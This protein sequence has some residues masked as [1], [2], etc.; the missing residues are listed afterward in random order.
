MKV[1][2]IIFFTIIASIYSSYAHEINVEGQVRQIDESFEPRRDVNKRLCSVIKIISDLEGFKYDSNNGIVGNVIDEPGRDYVYVS[3]DERA[4]YVYLAGFPRLTVILRDTG[5]R[6]EENQIWELRLAA[7]HTVFMDIL[8]VTL[9]IKPEDASVFIDNKAM[10]RGPTFQ[11][12]MG[13]HDIS[14]KKEGYLTKTDTLFVSSEQV[15]FQYHLVIQPDMVLVEG[16]VYDMGG[17]RW[18]EKPVHKVNLSSFE[19][20]KT[21]VTQVQWVAVMGSNPSY[22]REIGRAHV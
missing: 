7:E 12:G 9:L 8:P 22:F 18:D 14:I 3:P 6:L 2:F 19:T 5:I 10:G 1:I 20:G 21:E 4:L 11:L 13:K 16:G 15:L 17:T